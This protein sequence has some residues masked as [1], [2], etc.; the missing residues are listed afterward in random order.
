MKVINTMKLVQR[1]FTVSFGYFVYVGFYNID[2]LQDLNS[3]LI[4]LSCGSIFSENS[5]LMLSSCNNQILTEN[6]FKIIN[7][8]FEISN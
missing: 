8:L 5:I 7:H 4:K 6:V 3:I 2:Y 1:I